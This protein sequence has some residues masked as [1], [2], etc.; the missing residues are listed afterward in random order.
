MASN[1]RSATRQVLQRFQRVASGRIDVGM[2]PG[3]D[4]MPDT[5]QKCPNRICRLLLLMSRSLIEMK[6]G[7]ERSQSVNFDERIYVDMDM[8]FL[9]RRPIF[10]A[11]SACVTWAW[12]SN[13]REYNRICCILHSPYWE[14]DDF[15]RESRCVAG[16]F[17]M[18]GKQNR[19]CL[20]DFNKGR[21]CA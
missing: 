1:P 16:R 10:I 15:A 19:P 7:P 12:Q 8:R 4:V 14:W 18:L 6:T 13:V 3:G 5:L 11:M 2:A 20:A 21:I 17:A 9:H